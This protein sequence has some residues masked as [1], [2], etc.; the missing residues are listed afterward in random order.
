MRRKLL[1]FLISGSALLA[2]TTPS[3][4]SKGGVEQVGNKFVVGITYLNDGV[5]SLCSGALVAQNIIATARH[6]VINKNGVYGT[7][8]VFSAPGV[9]LEE[10]IDATQVPTKIN[11]FIIPQQTPTAGIDTRVDLAFIVTDTP[12]S[13][14]TP[15]PV[16]TPEDLLQ[17]NE[18]SQLSAYGYGAVYETK[19]LYSSLPRKFELSWAGNVLAEGSESIYEI[20]DDNNVAC[21]G[22][23]G[24]PITFKLENGKEVLIGVIN[25]AAEV[26]IECGS[27]LED[28][29][30]RTRFTAVAPHLNQIPKELIFVAPKSK[31]ITCTKGAKK[32]IIKGVNPKCPKG[33]KLKK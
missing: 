20:V 6:C 26:F 29:K 32:K 23:S 12:F 17:L 21:Q 10:P 28:N 2:P 27:K 11:K 31:K 33:Y 18:Q 24:G 9:R 15:I 1:T 13:K 7:N 8:Y 5:S 22:D 14:G 16:A 25:S 19:D 3:Y 30:Y 4:A